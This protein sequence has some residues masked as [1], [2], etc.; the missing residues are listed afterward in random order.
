MPPTPPTGRGGGGKTPPSSSSS[1]S[2][3][4]NQWFPD[5]TKSHNASA[6]PKPPKAKF[7][8]SGLSEKAQQGWESGTKRFSSAA[9][10]AKSFTMRVDTKVDFIGPA[11]ES[12]NSTRDQMWKLVPPFMQNAIVKGYPY[13]G[14]VLVTSVGTR[15]YCRRRAN[16]REA[17]LSAELATLRSRKVELEGTVQS[18][19]TALME[20]K[21][22][23]A[24][25]AGDVLQMA[26]HVAMATKA[27]AAAAEAAA[28]A[29]AGCQ[30]RGGSGMDG[31]A[32][33]GQYPM[34][35]YPFP[36]PP[37]STPNPS[38]QPTAPPPK[39]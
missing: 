7:S 31:G 10:D 8:W 20:S 16:A 13:A 6:I 19:D 23:A 15:Y 34:P 14:T 26:K 24:Q 37:P 30:R 9:A 27:A 18:L 25:P 3:G 4:G 32:T 2:S 21:L 17:V 33:N 36:G 29:S 1:S 22:K 35:P 28:S 5:P 38:S 12:A 11:L 39:R